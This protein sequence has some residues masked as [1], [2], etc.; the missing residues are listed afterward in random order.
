M[1]GNLKM[2]LVYVWYLLLGLLLWIHW[3]ASPAGVDRRQCEL[4]CS[5]SCCRLA[6][7][8]CWMLPTILFQSLFCLWVFSWVTVRC[9]W[10]V[11][12]VAEASE[13]WLTTKPRQLAGGVRFL[14]Q[15]PSVDSSP[16]RVCT[17]C[18]ETCVIGTMSLECKPL[19][20][21]YA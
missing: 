18:P 16:F 15:S 17:F 8:N 9:G 2:C 13:D 20:R 5:C 3:E 12:I 19:K 4:H 10:P 21:V 14:I 11:P 7:G 6:E 1:C